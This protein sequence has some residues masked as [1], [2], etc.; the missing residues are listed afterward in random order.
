L[1]REKAAALEEVKKERRERAEEM[2]AR[3]ERER[4]RV[5]ELEREKQEQA[6]ALKVMMLELKKV[7]QSLN[8]Q[9]TWRRAHEAAVLSDTVTYH[10]ACKDGR[11]VESTLEEDNGT[12]FMC[13]SDE[14]S[15]VRCHHFIIILTQ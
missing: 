5:Q 11:V 1:A 9:T 10:L 13:H 8:E 4:A 12:S 14:A 2:R 3:E 7:K 15:G 6:D